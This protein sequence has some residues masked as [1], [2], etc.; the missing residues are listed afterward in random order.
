MPLVVAAFLPSNANKL[1]HFSPESNRLVIKCC[2]IS[3][4]RRTFPNEVGF[5]LADNLRSLVKLP[6]DEEDWVDDDNRVVLE[7]VGDVPWHEC[8]IAVTKSHNDVPAE[9]EIGAIWLEPSSVRL[10]CG[11]QYESLGVLFRLDTYQS[12]AV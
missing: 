6:E 12:L 8:S 1:E 2:L 3:I 9:P 11:C 4:D 7:E 5:V 10:K